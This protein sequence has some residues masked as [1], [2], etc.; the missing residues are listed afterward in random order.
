MKI[1]Q[2]INDLWKKVNFYY[3]FERVLISTIISVNT[4]LFLKYFYLSNIYIPI[5][6]LLTSY[7]MYKYLRK[8]PNFEK[9]L[10]NADKFFNLEESLITLWEYKEYNE[11]YGIMK[12]LIYELENKLSNKSLK[13]SY[14]W[15]PSKLLSILT[16]IMIVLI[17][18]NI[19]NSYSSIQKHKTILKEENIEQESSLKLKENLSSKIQISKNI[20]GEKITEEKREKEKT[21]VEKEKDKVLE[22]LLSE[23]DFEE[24]KLIEE[25]LQKKTT[26]SDEKNSPSKIQE[27]KN[28]QQEGFSQNYMDQKNAFLRE[29]PNKEFKSD[30]NISQGN[31]GMESG[32][33]GKGIERDETIKDLNIDSSYNK[34]EKDKEAKGSLPGIEERKE[35]LGSKP[36][37]RL[38]VEAEKVYVPSQGIDESKKKVY[39]FEAPS[40]KEEKEKV[41]TPIN[42]PVISKSESP[43]YP[44]LIP[45]DLQE[46]I[47]SYFSE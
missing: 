23:W 37:P 46:I 24:E 4:F 27:E 33:L 26:S 6:L 31:F 12:K 34:S 28:I 42:S 43:T 16:L 22:K 45:Q 29:N 17:I 10:L 41:I 44:R 15:K 14:R 32:E 2:E 35:K 40:I 30:K 13:T 39:L 1:F 18:L 20:Q 7:L 36:T 9:V 25:L 19:L 47:K 38:N 5:L 21:S 8:R 3:L 11:P